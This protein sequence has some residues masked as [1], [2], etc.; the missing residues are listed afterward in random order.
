M[1]GNCKFWPAN[2]FITINKV[3]ICLTCGW[4]LLTFSSN[5]NLFKTKL[6]WNKNVTFYYIMINKNY[7]VVG[8]AGFARPRNT[9]KIISKFFLINQWINEWM[10]QSGVPRTAHPPS[11]ITFTLQEEI[12]RSALGMF[13]SNCHLIVNKV[14]LKFMHYTYEIRVV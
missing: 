2:L 1:V 6:L 3:F 5:K 7:Y 9:L 11:K 8:D 10:N 14:I 4:E 13:E 12:I